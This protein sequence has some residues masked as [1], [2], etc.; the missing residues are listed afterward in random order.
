MPLW[1]R[2][3]IV[4][5]VILVTLVVARLIDRWIARRAE[6]SADAITR[7][8]VLRRTVGAAIIFVGVLSALLAIPQVRT[9]AGGLLASSAVSASS[10]ALRRNARS[11][12]SSPAS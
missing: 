1:Q 2:L 12:I 6:R 8:R 3:I 9:V 5:V 7:Y 11:E 4:G 10:S